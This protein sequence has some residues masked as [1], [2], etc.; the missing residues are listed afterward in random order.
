[1]ITN[2]ADRNVVREATAELDKLTAEV[3][4]LTAELEAER[5]RN[6]TLTEI[7]LTLMDGG[8]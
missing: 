1:M 2:R 6:A 4:R 5:M 3:A 8:K 7:A